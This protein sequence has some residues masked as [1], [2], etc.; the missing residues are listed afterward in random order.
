MTNSSLDAMIHRIQ[1]EK[2]R[3]SEQ[4]GGTP[5]A[6]PSL[7]GDLQPLP[8]PALSGGVGTSNQNGELPGTEVAALATERSAATVQVLSSSILDGD[9][10]GS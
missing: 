8:P 9:G 4:G 7:R 2:Q 3:R 5:S 10:E 6:A 1:L